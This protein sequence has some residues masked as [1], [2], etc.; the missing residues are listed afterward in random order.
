MLVTWGS[1]RE[2]FRGLDHAELRELIK[3]RVALVLALVLVDLS[4]GLGETQRDVHAGRD[5]G[6][7]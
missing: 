2:P 3:V 6:K 4:F 5:R 7:G 1:L